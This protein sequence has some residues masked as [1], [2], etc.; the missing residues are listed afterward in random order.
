M[1]TAARQWPGAN[2]TFSVYRRNQTVKQGN[3][4]VPVAAGATTPIATGISLLLKD[5]SG[6]VQTDKGGATFQGMYLGTTFIDTLI[7]IG[8]ILADEVE[9]DRFGLPV[10]YEVQGKTIGALSTKMHLR[11]TEIGV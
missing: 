5:Q 11:R 6:M 3:N 1:S 4:T 10:R 8:D 9:V 7:M 2:K